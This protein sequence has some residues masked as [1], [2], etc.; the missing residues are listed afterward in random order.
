MYLF[1]DK[2]YHVRVLLAAM[3]YNGHLIR[4]LQEDDDGEK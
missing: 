4:Q 1:S 2:S 3:D